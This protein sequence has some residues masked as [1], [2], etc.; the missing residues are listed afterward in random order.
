MVS[1]M[2]LKNGL[3]SVMTE[4][5]IV[6]FFAADVVPPSVLASVF[7]PERSQPAT[8]SESE[9]IATAK[10]EIFIVNLLSQE[11]LALENEGGTAD[12]YIRFTAPNRRKELWL[13]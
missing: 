12:V 8:I 13:G 3:V 11:M 1:P 10:C 2:T 5:P 9:T 4:T 6:P 7:P